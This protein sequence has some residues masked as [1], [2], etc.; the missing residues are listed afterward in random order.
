MLT[1]LTNVPAHDVDPSYYVDWGESREYTVGDMGK[2]ECAG[3]VVSLVEFE[4]SGCETEAFEAQLRM[5]DGKYQEAYE[6]AYSAMLH[7]AKALVRT[8][9]FDVPADPETV[10]KEFRERFCDTELFYNQFAG[11]KFANYLFRVHEEEIANYTRDVAHQVVE[12]TQLFI[13]QAYSCY[14]RMNVVNA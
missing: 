3:E 1:D 8:Q 5:D 6:T 11:A 7:A 13:E 2:G 10:I 9:W 4:L 12:E 14:G